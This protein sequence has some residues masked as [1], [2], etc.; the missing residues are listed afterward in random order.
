MIFLRKA[1]MRPEI[2]PPLFRITDINSERWVCIQL[3]PSIIISAILYSPFNNL[4][5]QIIRMGLPLLGLFGN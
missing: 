5:R 3:I 2:F 4:T 1:F